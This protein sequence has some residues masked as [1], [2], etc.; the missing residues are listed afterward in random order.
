MLREKKVIVTKELLSAIDK[1][2]SSRT[3]N[4]L[5][6]YQLDKRLIADIIRPLL[7][8]YYMR[9][10][11]LASEPERSKSLAI[12]AGLSWWATNGTDEVSKLSQKKTTILEALE[13]DE[14]KAQEKLIIAS[15]HNMP[16]QTR[17]LACGLLLDLRKTDG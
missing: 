17:K 12:N 2:I 13:K 14:I 3:I 11:N 15:S 5:G 7:N 4:I 9:Y 1:E 8:I 10:E 16:L 6:I